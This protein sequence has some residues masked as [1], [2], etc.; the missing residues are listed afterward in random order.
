MA[1]IKAVKSEIKSRQ[2]ITDDSVL[3]DILS[4]NKSC[5]PCC[6]PTKWRTRMMPTRTLRFERSFG[7]IDLQKTTAH[8]KGSHLG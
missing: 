3:K 6:K 8:E 4:I 5:E 1:V 2:K 7:L